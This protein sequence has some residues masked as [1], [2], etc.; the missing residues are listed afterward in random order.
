MPTHPDQVLSH[1]TLCILTNFCRIS[2]QKQ[3]LALLLILSSKRCFSS[4]LSSVFSQVEVEQQKKSACP[5]TG[6]HNAISCHVAHPAEKVHNLLQELQV[7]YL[8]MVW[9]P[10]C[11]FISQLRGLKGL[12][13]TVVS[14]DP[15]VVSGKRSLQGYTSHS[16]QMNS[17]E[18]SK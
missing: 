17:L 13:L 18:W 16:V 10:F 7:L 9:L 1:I 3:N 12:S 8:H 14:Q 2:Q 6:R 11:A 4:S 5:R 15:Y